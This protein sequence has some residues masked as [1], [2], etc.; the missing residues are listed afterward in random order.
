AFALWIDH[1]PV[2]LH[3]GHS[4]PRSR[5]SNQ[6]MTR[7]SS[8]GYGISESPTKCTSRSVRGPPSR[9]SSLRTGTT[10]S[11]DETRAATLPP[12]ARKVINPS[13]RSIAGPSRRTISSG[14]SLP[15][16]V[17]AS[18]TL[19][20]IAPGERRVVAIE[21]KLAREVRPQPVPLTA[22]GR[23]ARSACPARRRRAVAGNGALAGGNATHVRWPAI[24]AGGVPQISAERNE[25]AAAGII[26]R[27]S[28]KGAR[29]R[30]SVL[31][32]RRSGALRNSGTASLPRFRSSLDRLEPHDASALQPHCVEALRAHRRTS[33]RHHHEYEAAVPS[34]VEHLGQYDPLPV[35]RSEAGSRRSQLADAIGARIPADGGMDLCRVEREEIAHRVLVATYRAIDAGL[36][37]V[38]EDRGRQIEAGRRFGQDDRIRLLL[39]HFLPRAASPRRA[40]EECDESQNAHAPHRCARHDLSASPTPLPTPP[41]LPRAPPR[42]CRPGR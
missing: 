40:G 23:P 24:F 6:R 35:Q 20:W 9:S 26:R 15:F 22:A 37:W 17:P 16:V 32:F 14:V 41:P 30:G 13:I 29:A 21:V 8:F 42:R 7:S 11:R 25:R 38:H 19:N 5:A 36:E 2:R 27:E 1:R 4:C 10:R 31:D 34:L 39:G 28:S 33:V 18:S 3:G 12:P